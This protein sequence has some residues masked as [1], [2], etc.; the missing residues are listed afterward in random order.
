MA[1]DVN[2]A[3]IIGRL[4]A[5]P[6]RVPMP[7]GS[8]IV[9][10][11]VATN[12]TWTD[13]ATGQAKKRTD[14]HRLVAKDAIGDRLAEFGE[15]GDKVYV[16]GRQRPTTYT[17]RKKVEQTVVDIEVFEL[18]FLGGSKKADGRQ[19]SSAEEKPVPTPPAPKEKERAGERTMKAPVAA[20]S[21]PTPAAVATS[22]KDVPDVAGPGAAPP[23][24]T[25]AFESEF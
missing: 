13:K 1:Q 23:G 2:V 14:W 19:G 16:R 22:P 24:D 5:K 9:R 6:E 18:R 11:R 3:L 25:I 15:Q 17:D 20:P 12:E 7:D 8:M 4:A 10:A 21:T